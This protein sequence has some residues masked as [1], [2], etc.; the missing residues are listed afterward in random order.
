M[1]VSQAAEPT[2]YAIV[3]GGEARNFR[4][5][6]SAQ[7][8]KILSDTLYRD[9]IL[10]VVREVLCNAVDAHIV[11]GVDRPV[12]V[13]LNAE[14]LVIRDF[15]PGIPDERMIEVYATYFGS[16]KTNDDSQIG[17]FGLGSK[18]PFAY[19]DHFTVT[20]CTGGKKRIYALTVGDDKNDGAPGC[21]LMA[22]VPTTE[23]GLTVQVPLENGADRQAFQDRLE[24]VVQQGGMKV[25]LNGK[26][27]AAPDLEPLRQAGYGALLTRPGMINDRYPSRKGDVKVLYASVAY[28]V[29]GAPRE[30]ERLFERLI[31]QTHPAY[32]FI[33]VAPPSSIGVTPSREGLSYGEKTV[34]T[35]TRLAETALREIEAVMPAQRRKVIRDRMIAEDCTLLTA[36]RALE[37]AF[38]RQEAPEAHTIHI[39]PEAVAYS[40]SQYR[41]FRHNSN[42]AEVT[43]VAATVVSGCRHR[44]RQ[45]ALEMERPNTA[46]KRKPGRGH[47]TRR[48]T[49][50]SPHR[51]DR[52]RTRHGS[53]YELARHETERRYLRIA[54]KF[55]L[56]K[57]LM[58]AGDRWNQLVPFT[59]ITEKSKWHPNNFADDEPH[60]V[61]G[62]QK[63]SLYTNF[64]IGCD[65]GYLVVP[66][67]TKAQIELIRTYAE[68]LGVKVEFRDKPAKLPPKLK[69]V[70][71]A[72][73]IEKD[74][75]RPLNFGETAWIGG[76]NRVRQQDP[77]EGLPVALF[78]SQ[79]ICRDGHSGHVI[80]ER[81]QNSGFTRAIGALFPADTVTK[82]SPIAMPYGL[83]E[84][85]ALL[86]KGVPRLH[87]LVLDLIEC[88]P[89]DA[90]AN[91]HLYF[92]M[93][94]T[95]LERYR[96]CGLTSYDENANFLRSM[97]GTDRRAACMALNLPYT[98]SFMEDHNYWLWRAACLLHSFH[99]DMAPGRDHDYRREHI[100]PITK[101]WEALIAGYKINIFGERP[102]NQG[103]RRL[104]SLNLGTKNFQN[105][106]WKRRE[107][108]EAVVEFFNSQDKEKRNG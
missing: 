23:T 100:E 107:D 62:E 20:S 78:E 94:K 7:A 29:A 97:I 9:K 27:L 106:D 21:R 75:Y 52:I 68:T 40:T 61:I 39:G 69:P 81:Y 14:E 49:I 102:M 4:I 82:A 80:N 12:E 74:T 55:G 6:Q 51:I 70:K 76:Q 28:E 33:L 96:L 92:A 90:R 99:H 66:G 36:Y 72:K 26:P 87:E 46:P 58:R 3:G 77:V 73:P 19:T 1:Q 48:P 79:I 32:T 83:R 98:P 63:S 43:A 17:G 95:T 84:I 38:Y 42:H 25:M 5:G 91:D 86:A 104:M 103:L 34:E 67:I 18:A 57:N 13:T 37:T 47:S 85:D 24:R 50:Y 31:E 8:F 105:Y 2:T 53:L 59:Q 54:K 15:G 88:R 11:A 22:T 101:R 71:I 108:F 56:L 65:I 44:L 45:L 10:A 64:S 16:T 41:L 60:L 30:L 89:F 35:L 93:A